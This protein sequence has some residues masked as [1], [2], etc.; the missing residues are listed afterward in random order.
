MDHITWRC[1]CG[2]VEAT[3]P[4]HGNRIICYCGSCRA[5]VEQLDAGNRLDQQGGNELFQVAP[6]GVRLTKGI[7]QLVW[8]RLTEKGPLRWYAKCCRTPMANTLSSRALPFASFQVHELNPKA[9]LPAV[10]AR[11]N[12]AGALGQVD[13]EKGSLSKLVL[14]LLGNAAKAHI[15]RRVAQNPFFGVDGKPVGPRLQPSQELT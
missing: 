9:A 14:G 12:L 7:D 10:K 1:T 5:F 11:V 4:S 6:D 13:G 8:M 2:E 15:M 3:L